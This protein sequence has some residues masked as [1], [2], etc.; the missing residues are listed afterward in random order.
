M[1]S[2]TFASGI[3]TTVATGGMSDLKLGDPR[4]RGIEL[5]LKS[6]ETGETHPRNTFDDIRGIHDVNRNFFGR[7]QPF[8]ENRFSSKA[9]ISGADQFP[10]LVALVSAAS[11]TTV[12]NNRAGLFDRR[13]ST[14]P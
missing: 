10:V 3:S 11:D 7:A 12:A 2:G 14:R 6:G 8:T 4:Q 1:D 13:L 5:D 9:S